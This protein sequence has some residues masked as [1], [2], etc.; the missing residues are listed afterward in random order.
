MQLRNVKIKKTLHLQPCR[1]LGCAIRMGQ[2]KLD[3]WATS[4]RP[5]AAISLFAAAA[6]G[7]YFAYWLHGAAP[8][9]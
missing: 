5:R 4:G 9:L 2:R 6:K 7:Q 3:S 8:Y 1:A